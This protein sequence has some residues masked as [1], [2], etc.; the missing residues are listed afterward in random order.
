MGIAYGSDT[1]KAMDILTQTGRTYHMASRAHPSNAFFCG[2]GDSSL[3]F[4]LRVFIKQADQFRTATH[5]LHM[6]I[7]NAF[8]KAG[9]AIAFP[10]MDVHMNPTT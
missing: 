10:Q 8:R 7:D 4:E 2:F 9:I 3:N 5:E 6:A 1:Q